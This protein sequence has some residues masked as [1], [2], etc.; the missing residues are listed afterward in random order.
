[1]DFSK[2]IFSHNINNLS[3]I[4]ISIMRKLI[5]THY[6]G[7]AV[8]F[9]LSVLILSPAA[10]QSARD[11]GKY[12]NQDQVTS[13][14]KDLQVKNPG[15]VK[16]HTI[17]ISP[18]KREVL[19]YEIGSEIS[20]ENKLNPA[21]LAVAN[22]EGNTPLGTEASL[23]LAE[24][25]LKD[26][27]RY[28]SLT[29]YILTSGNP[30]AA[31]RFFK[32]P[33]YKDP[34]NDLAVNDDMDDQTDEDGYNDLDGNG[35]ITMMRVKSPDGE[36]LPVVSDP[37]LMKKA[38]PSKGEKGIYKLY[39]EG[40]DD[41]K[42]GK[43]NEDV[44]GGTNVGLNFPHLFK[45]FVPENGLFPGSSP[46]AFGLI[47]FVFSHPEIAMTFSFG[48][49]NFC[50]APPKGG[51][52]GSVDME[53]ISIPEDIAKAFG[54]DPSKTYSMKEIMELVKPMVPAGIDLDENMIASFLGLGAIVNPLNEDLAFYKKLSEDYAEYLKKAG[55]TG[56]RFDPEDGKDGSFELW[57]YYHLGVPVF[58]MDLWSIPKPKEEKT[59]SSGITPESIENMSNEDFLAI[60]EEK[61]SA[62]MKE[63]GAPPQYKAS[64]VFKGVKSG[65]MTPKQ[66]GGMMKQIP[67]PSKDENTGDPKEK[68]ILAFS[69]KTAGSS[70]FV[71][72]TKFNHPALG[73]VEIGG[74]IP[75]SDN[76]PPPS[77]IDSLIK[78]QVPW[79]FKLTEQL[80]V[81]KISDTKI[82][83]KGSG[84]YQLEVWISNEKYLPYP[85]AMG[86]KNKQPAPVICTLEGNGITFLSGKKRMVI[87]SIPG[88]KNSKITWLIQSEKG[89]D[90][91]LRLISKSAGNDIKQIKISE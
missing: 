49:S 37:R 26:K 57:S 21:V 83:S 77:M 13:I 75:Y 71:N 30:D 9:L 11:T 6:P 82:T 88:L 17:A 22:M 45:F 51:R 1:L 18:G 29:W 67:K 62:F 47:K 68:A 33:L 78:A 28:K 54:A 24:S 5:V 64:M 12:H 55:L 60:G 19:L 3:L 61:F 56:D 4:F 41:D 76:T 15:T 25:I 27:E 10:G 63:A 58:S 90:L 46:E 31:E 23:Y 34:R 35:I 48:S 14:M 87:Q 79:I 40:L 80:P 69:D 84:L 59:S 74:F 65:Q 50:L 86:N 91:T 85:T 7:I 53:K 89:T 8:L 70:G 16:I 52:S 81:L 42:D 38:D 72:W 36:W 2:Q 20:S 44:P 43:Y 32:K 39:T 73:E 66:I